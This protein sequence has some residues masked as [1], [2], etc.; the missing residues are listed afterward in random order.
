MRPK[1]V[2]ALLYVLSFVFTEAMSIQKDF[3][4]ATFYSVMETGKI[5][6]VNMQLEIIKNSSLPEKNAFEG[7]LLMKKAGMVT[8]PANKLS[9]FKAG[10]KKL[11]AEIK[12]DS[13]NTELRF[14]RLI[15]QEHAPG[16]LGYKSE[17]Q[18]DREYIRMNFKKLLPAV[19]HAVAGYSQKSKI[20]RPTDLIL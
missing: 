7:T 9:L 3:D 11:E 13:S 6:D 16:I 12:K 10:H 17:L 20:L 18:K 8:V 15:I 1:T 4:R 14:L 5:E 19:Q 2:F